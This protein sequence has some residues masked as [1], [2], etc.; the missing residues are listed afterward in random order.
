VL[1]TFID[2]ILTLNFISTGAST[3]LRT[4]ILILTHEAKM[5]GKKNQSSFVGIRTPVMKSEWFGNFG[6]GAKDFRELLPDA[7]PDD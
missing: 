3:L 6:F 1:F 7:R 4:S 2:V 5:G